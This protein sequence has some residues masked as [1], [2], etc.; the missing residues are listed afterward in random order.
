ML[1]RL[2]QSVLI[3]L[4]ALVLSAYQQPTGDGG[5]PFWAI[6]V[7]IL[8][9]IIFLLWLSAERKRSSAASPGAATRSKSVD[10][11]AT[12]SA[13][14][15]EGAV[16]PAGPDDLEVIEGIGPKIAGVLTDAGISTFT[17]LAE[18]SVEQLEDILRTA[19]IRLADPGTWPTQARLAATGQWD[20]FN[21][22]TESL[23][24]GR[25][26]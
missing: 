25:E 14:V 20:E 6:I 22:Y 4:I 3:C 18:T 11:A 12:Q 5:F 19:G 15:I 7:L 16:V 8:V 24:G 21:R 26:A 10:Y 9:W 1:K 23:K 2:G 17:Q 13:P